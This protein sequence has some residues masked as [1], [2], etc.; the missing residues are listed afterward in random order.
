MTPFRICVLS[1]VAVFLTRPGV[2]RS[3][4]VVEVPDLRSD[5]VASH[6][7]PRVF[8]T[9]GDVARARERV[10][11]EDYRRVVEGLNA[12]ADA[13]LSLELTSMDGRWW[14]EVKD[15]DW[16]QTYP[17]IYEKTCLDPLRM[18]RPAYA[19]AMRYAIHERPQD[20]AAVKRIL[21][22]LSEYSFAYEH[23]DVGMNY[24]VW[25]HLALYAYDLC[26][27]QWSD[28]ERARLDAFF[29]RMGRAVLKNDVYWIENNIGG[30]INNHLAWHK[31]MLGGLGVFYGRD[32][33]VDYA[34][35]GPRGLVWLL[36]EGLV[37]DGL[38]CE[39]SLTYHFTAIVPMV[40]LAE[41]LRHAGH[42]EDLY[43]MATPGGRNIRQAY[44]AMFGVLFP[45]TTVPPIG[46][47][48]GRR[49]TLGQEFTYWPAY[50]AYGDPRYGWLLGRAEP[51]RPEL[52]FIGADVARREVPAVSSR[53]Y[54]EHGY[55]FLRNR[56]GAEYWD[57]E[58]WCAFVTFDKSG[59]H[60]HQDKLSLMLFGCG[61]L[62]LADV[63][64]KATVPH[65]FSSQVQ[66]ELNR[67]GLSQNTVMVDYR[68]QRGIDRLLPLLEYNDS[69][70][71]KRVT[72]ADDHGLLYAGIRQ[73]RTVLVRDEYVLDVFQVVGDSP[74]D[75]AW[76][77][78]TIGDPAM[79][80]CSVQQS[81][82]AVEIP[83]PGSWLRHFRVGVTDEVI[84][85]R[86]S[87]DDVHLGMTMAAQPGT[88]VMTCG[89]P[90]SDEPDCPTTPMMI[91]ER[92]VASTIY[93]AVYQAGKGD[94]PMIRITRGEDG[95]D[96]VVYS[97]EGPWGEHR[98][99]VLRLK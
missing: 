57:G 95:D 88:K 99:R 81:P 56:Q 18:T 20:L 22:H 27:R 86:W 58:G 59:V 55:T 41:A 7:Y 40:Q 71:E 54:A 49:M 67:G 65:A 37:D 87:E 30:G 75:I 8:C 62:L 25:G 19:A 85:M 66:R 60:C 89:Y 92:H 39:S 63:E 13:A 23:Y 78:H 72:V 2:G 14:E 4:S 80:W 51:A 83:G 28:V 64:A 76:I 96:Q 26:F 42:R 69:P 93:A 45:D 6:G 73:S 17:I 61:K 16:S 24:A 34:L 29:A 31:M 1:A 84:R 3:L 47:A 44:D 43:R 33:L 9:P 97:V 74:H 98:H 32:E 91:V 48:Y 38:W 77:I 21:L 79:Q 12:E 35:R 15:K 52:L 94:L 36:D 11:R 50:R 5:A 70:D 46:D 90:S 10:G 82:A 68:D 53:V